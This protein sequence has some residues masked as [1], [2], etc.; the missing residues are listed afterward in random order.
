MRWPPLIVTV[1]YLALAGLAAMALVASGIVDCYEN[2]RYDTV[3]PAWRYDS[4]AWQWTA[5]FWLGTCSLVASITFV[6]TAWRFRP[7]IAALA[8]AVNLA[9]TTAGGLLVYDEGEVSVLGLALT[10]AG[11]AGLGCVLILTRQKTE[12]QVSQ[13]SRRS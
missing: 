6:V 11:L 9:S 8:L 1:A 13:K 3:H 10:L 7:A 12:R 4:S 2:C 5:L